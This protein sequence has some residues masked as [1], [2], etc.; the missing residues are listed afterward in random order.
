MA[1]CK[2]LIGKHCYL[3]P[4]SLEDAERYTQWLND[5]EVARTLQTADQVITAHGEVRFLETLSQGHNYGI[6]DI[7]TDELLGNCGFVSLD[8]RNRSGE[9][10]I[11]IGRKDFW[12]Q[13]IGTEAL[14]LLIRYGFDYLNLH[15]I[16]IRVYEMNDRG[17]ACYKKIGFREI[18]RQ[19]QALCREGRYWDIIHLDLLREE[20]DWRPGK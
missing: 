8:D 20:F 5:L 14:R 19:R 13:G 10:G 4:I 17:L 1:Y 7:K 2:K 11:F 12:G 9:A 16:L 18:G 6:V 15:S 3:S